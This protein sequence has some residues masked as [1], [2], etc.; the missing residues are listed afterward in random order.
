MGGNSLSLTNKNN[1][2]QN[3]VTFF[4]FNFFC[5]GKNL[6]YVQSNYE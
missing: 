3:V 4:I 1:L 6:S 2:L 5:G